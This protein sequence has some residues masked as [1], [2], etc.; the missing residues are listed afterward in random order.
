LPDRKGQTLRR[1]S[2]GLLFSCSAAQLVKGF[3]ISFNI[4][5]AQAQTRRDQPIMSTIIKLQRQGA[6]HKPFWRVVVTDSR[7]PMG[8]IE[9]LGTYD[10]MQ[11]PP[12]LQIDEA[13]AA[14]WVSKGAKPTPS[15]MRL[16]AGKGVLKKAASVPGA[17]A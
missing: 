5:C 16:F 2:C 12:L 1:F 17:G 10:N 13:K 11:K 6:P 3:N 9:L 14:L 15:V 4:T 7:K 8:T